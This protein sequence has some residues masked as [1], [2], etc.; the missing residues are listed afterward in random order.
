MNA[1]KEMIKYCK[2]RI[3]E[4]GIK[5]GKYSEYIRT[6]IESDKKKI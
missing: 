3:K 1:T 5:N 2:A 6:L 4:T